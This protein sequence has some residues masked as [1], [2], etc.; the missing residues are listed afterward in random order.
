MKRSVRRMRKLMPVRT[1]ALWAARVETLERRALM[2]A[3]DLDPTFG[4]GDGKVLEE[5]P[6]TFNVGDAAF[7]LP[8]GKVL[9]GGRTDAGYAIARYHAD[10]SP[11]LGFGG[12]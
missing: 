4:G 2:A 7:F 6:S 12:G 5:F 11:D 9:V 3:G 1:R 10:G 8:G